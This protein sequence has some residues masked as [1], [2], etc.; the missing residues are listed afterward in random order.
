MNLHERVNEVAKDNSLN[1]TALAARI[2]L[3]YRTVQNYLAERTQPSAEFLINMK[4]EFGVSATWL[5][6]GDGPKLVPEWDQ[7][8]APPASAFVPIPRLSVS[9][10]A[11]PG[12][13]VEGEEAAGYL[14]FS[15]DWLQR[16]G[17]AADQ[18]AVINVSGDSMEPRLRG[19]DL[20]LVD[21]SQNAVR[22]GQLYVVRAG[23]DVLVKIIARAGPDQL[24]LVSTN[25]IYPP[26]TISP[27]EAAAGFNVIGRVVASMAEW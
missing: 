26:R 4:D 21:Q 2:E 5:L 27:T 8:E 16:R 13:F 20:I 7:S 10:S 12:Q 1:I 11:G 18:L 17:L 3:P 14:A 19:G 23:E 24:T 15:R 22:D 9:A 25:P 6:T